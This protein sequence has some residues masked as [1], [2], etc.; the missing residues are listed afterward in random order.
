M[1][2]L[3]LEEYQTKKH[4]HTCCKL[5]ILDLI[6][7]DTDQDSA[8]RTRHASWLRLRA[9]TR[10]TSAGSFIYRANMPSFLGACCG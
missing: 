8:Q 1:K 5:G 4:W 6:L 7:D 9:Q 2:T 3:L 10:A